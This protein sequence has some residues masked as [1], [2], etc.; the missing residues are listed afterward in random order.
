MIRFEPY[1]PEHS[2]RIVPLWNES[3]AGDFPLDQRLWEQ[4]VDNCD[5]TDWGG[6][7]AAF[8]EKRM[9]GFVV[10]KRP[11]HIG[12]IVVHPK[13]RRQGIGTQLLDLAVNG[14]MPEKGSRV[15]VGQDYLHFFPGIP[16]NCLAAEAFFT[17]NGWDIIDAGACWDLH[18]K[19]G[20]Y[21]TPPKV[22]AKI[23]ELEKQGVVIRPCEPADTEALFAHVAANFSERWLS[24]TRSRVAL[25]PTPAEIIVAARGSEIVGFCHTFSTKSVKIG[26]SIYWR[27][28]LG[29]HY[30]GL[31]PIGVAK[32]VR[33]IGLGLALL[34]SSVEAVKKT[35]ATQM[36]I[37]WTVLVDFYG[38]IGFQ[39]WKRYVPASRTY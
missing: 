37:D 3:F 1:L 10:A 9:I 35:G 6:T 26:P 13:Y 14:L 23:G 8:D 36:A 2:D 24:E 18:R 5:R 20:D 39:P 15:L 38:I 21:A 33:K 19:L 25:E 4:N 22:K 17:A 32:D 34:C 30:G 11:S 31:G 27:G 29:D 7:Y 16:E 28:L 12:A